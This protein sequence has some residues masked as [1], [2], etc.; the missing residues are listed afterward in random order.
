MYGQLPARTATVDQS[1]S[2][3]T[4][5]CAQQ[6]GV[7]Q[8]PLPAAG[9]GLQG[10]HQ[11]HR[12]AV[13]AAQLKHVR[14]PML[15]LTQTTNRWHNEQPSSLS[16][17]L[18]HL[19]GPL[20]RVRCLHTLNSPSQSTQGQRQHTHQALPYVRSALHCIVPHYGCALPSAAGSQQ[21]LAHA[22]QLV[23]HARGAIREGEEVHAVDG[24]EARTGGQARQ[25][26]AS[27][28]ISSMWRRS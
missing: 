10:H 7:N 13:R 1:S 23:E 21:R 25:L 8:Q 17:R 26:R 24:P 4:L 16:A 6:L 19:P 12:V 28:R 22:R 9:A 2:A 5:R 11:Q 3:A 15:Q 27:R 14:V 18:N 20:P